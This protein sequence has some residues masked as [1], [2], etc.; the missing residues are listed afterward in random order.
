MKTRWVRL[1]SEKFTKS[2]NRITREN[3]TT[4]EPQNNFVCH[5]CNHKF[6][7]KEQFRNHVEAVHDTRFNFICEHCGETFVEGDTLQ[8]HMKSIHKAHVNF[9]C[10]QCEQTYEKESDLRNHVETTHFATL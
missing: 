5:Q 1:N 6:T 10:K 3:I 9:R 7:E 2:L 4:I 8:D